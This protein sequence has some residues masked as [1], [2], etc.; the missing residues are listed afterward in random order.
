MII[1]FVDLALRTIQSQY[2]TSPHIVG[3]IEKFRA[4]IDPTTD[5]ETFY[6]DYFDPRTAVGVGLDIWGE[7]VGASRNIEVDETEYFGF[8]GSLLHPFDQAPFYY[9]KGATNIYRLPDDAFRQLIFIKAW[10]NISD[11][12]LPNVKYVLQKIINNN[13]TIINMGDMTVRVLFLT[14]D[15]KP[16]ELAMLKQYGLQNLGAGVGWDY[17]IIDPKETFGFEG[18]GLQNFDNGI[19]APYNVVEQTNKEYNSEFVLGFKG[20]GGQTLDHGTFDLD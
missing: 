6:H 10:A 3:I 12:T 19:F 2:G 4:R 15:V 18:S 11:A 1:D 8:Q 17:Y 13:I 5:I 9:E 16:F 7:I 14:Y 20:S